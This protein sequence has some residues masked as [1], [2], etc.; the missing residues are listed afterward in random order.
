M[1]QPKYDF[2]I[3]FILIEIVKYD[4]LCDSDNTYVNM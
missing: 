4:K 2:F 3:D 1:K